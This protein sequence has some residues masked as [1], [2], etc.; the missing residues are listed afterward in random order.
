M[1]HGIIDIGSNT[2]RMAIYDIKGQQID[3]LIKWEPY[4]RDFGRELGDQASQ[5]I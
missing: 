3:F 2:I 5:R 1:I 4:T